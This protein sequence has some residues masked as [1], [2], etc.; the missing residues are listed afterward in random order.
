MVDN[1]THRSSKAAVPGGVGLR[2]DLVLRSR[3]LTPLTYHSPII[4]TVRDRIQ[5]VCADSLYTGLP[6]L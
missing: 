5:F 2:M 4:F 6:A 3:A 1:A